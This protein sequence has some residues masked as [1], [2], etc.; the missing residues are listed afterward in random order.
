MVCV[1]VHVCVCVCVC[2]CN[3]QGITNSDI[4]CCP[5]EQLAEERFGLAEQQMQ[6]FL[7]RDDASIIK[8]LLRGAAA[9]GVF[10]DGGGGGG[11]G[12]TGPTASVLTSS[13]EAPWAAGSV[14]RA[15]ICQNMKQSRHTS[16]GS[17]VGLPLTTIFLSINLST[18]LPISR[19]V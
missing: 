16:H 1:C 14:Y 15:S 6:Q 8:Q 4:T 13:S 12:E 2:V 18:I 7:P 19:L 11:G 5:C 3:D 9:D 17:G 10:K